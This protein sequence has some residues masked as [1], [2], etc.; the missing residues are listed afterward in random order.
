MSKNKSNEALLEELSD[1]Q[2]QGAQGGFKVEINGLKSRLTQP[3]SA[4]LR[5]ND[6]KTREPGAN[7]GSKIRGPSGDPN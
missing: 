3:E 4:G 5:K 7:P 6:S 1:E 2:L